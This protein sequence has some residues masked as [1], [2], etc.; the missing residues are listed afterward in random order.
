MNTVNMQNNLPVQ[1]SHY[2]AKKWDKYCHF[3]LSKALLSKFHIESG[4]TLASVL[5][6][7]IATASE[8]LL[9]LS[10]WFTDD[11][12]GRKCLYNQSL[13]VSKAFVQ[14]WGL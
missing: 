6:F 7:S 14:T 1:T 3:Y 13:K 10:I 8:K 5:F 4:F 2:S 12:P 9:L 11:Y